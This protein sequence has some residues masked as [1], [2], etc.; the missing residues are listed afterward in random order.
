MLKDER[1]DLFAFAL[2]RESPEW[3]DRRQVAYERIR[4]RRDHDLTRD[5]TR[6]EPGGEIHSVTV[7]D[8]VPQFLAPDV[9]YKRCTCRNPHPESGERWVL[10][11]N[12]LDGA[13]HRKSRPG[14]GESVARLL[15]WC[16]PDR[17]DR[18]SSELDDRAAVGEEHCANETGRQVV[19]TA[20]PSAEDA[21]GE[22]QHKVSDKP[23]ERF[24]RVG[25]GE[26]AERREKRP[27][28][29][30]ARGNEAAQHD[31]EGER[32]SEHEAEL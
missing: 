21:D 1:F 30:D 31:H 5:R 28:N 13:L 9:A 25:E 17:H 12:G 32:E 6:L 4:R 3:A 20:Q 15:D 14:S 19:R 16:V 23:S 22:D 10:S 29:N 27:E 8:V 2:D 24:T 26:G 7:C 11:D 18:V